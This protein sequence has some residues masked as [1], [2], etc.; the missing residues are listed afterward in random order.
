MPEGTAKQATLHD[1]AR[2][3]GVSHQTVSR[4]INDSPNVS[5]GTRARVNQAIETLNYRPNRAA[6]SLI[7]G[8]SQTIQVIDFAATY[9]MPIPEIVRQTNAFNYR[10]GVSIL[11]DEVS[12]EELR[13]LMDDLTSRL[14]DG[15]L[16]FSPQVCFD[17]RELD[18]L[19]RGI[20]YVQMAGE[21]AIGIPAVLIDNKAGVEQGMAHLIGLGH[22]RIAEIGGPAAVYDARIR[23]QTYLEQM[24]AAGLEPGPWL[25]GDFSAEK[26]YELSLQLLAGP[27]DFSAIVCAND[28]S[29]LGVLRALHERGLRVPE[30]IS[31]VGFDDHP[32]VKFYEPPLTTMRQDYQQL[33]REAVQLL[34]EL[35][36]EPQSPVRQV[37]LPP[38]LVVRQ[39][40]AR[41]RA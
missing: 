30:D 40:T 7:T 20:P 16:L 24:A 35:I 38:T 37:V 14:V 23:H 34:V 27:R 10:V 28:D 8:R 31:V 15:F 39:S 21:P 5:E 29:A 18:R 9:L 6:R 25:A 41:F 2:L 32:P 36:K 13:Q 12:T 19:C 3:V 4:V 11:R 26:A 22:R 17:K 1:V 33:S